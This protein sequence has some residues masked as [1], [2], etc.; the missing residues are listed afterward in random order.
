MIA[1]PYNDSTTVMY[2]LKPRLPMKLSLFDLMK[3]LDYNKIDE[4]I[5]K[6]NERKAVVRF[7][8]MDLESNVN[9]DKAL[10][11]VGIKSMFSPDEANFALMI[12]SSDDKKENEVVIRSRFGHEQSRM[13]KDALNSLPNPGVYVDSVLHNVKITVN[14]KSYY[15]V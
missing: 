6:M 4:L 8:K 15:R 13:L 1:L 11:A 3:K 10:K 2:A 14:G 12:D 5:N 9:L 7:P